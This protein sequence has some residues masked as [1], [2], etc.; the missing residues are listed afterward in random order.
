M[1]AQLSLRPK[2]C[3]AVVEAANE[4][5][6]S[7]VNHHEVIH[8]AAEGVAG[9]KGGKGGRRGG[10]R[11]VY[12]TLWTNGFSFERFKMIPEMSA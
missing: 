3:D 11:A 6:Y 12:A 4:L 10:G 8:H 1:T 5:L 2:R 9:G 7:S